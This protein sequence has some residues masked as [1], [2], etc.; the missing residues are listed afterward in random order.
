[1]TEGLRKAAG[2]VPE[3]LRR[4]LRALWAG[5]REVSGDSAYERY[6]EHQRRQGLCNMLSRQEFYCQQV[7]RKYSGKSG[8]ARCC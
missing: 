7:E 1:M 3:R 2:T 4:R 6:L 8:P 5:I